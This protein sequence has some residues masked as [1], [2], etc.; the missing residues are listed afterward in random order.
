MTASHLSDEDRARQN[1]RLRAIWRKDAPRYDKMMGFFERRVLGTGHREWVCSRATGEVLEVAVG[2]GLNLPLYAPDVKLSA[3][4]LSPEMLALAHRRASDLGRDVELREADAHALPFENESFDSVVCTYAL[5]N[6]P[7]DRLAIHE[8]KRVLRPGGRLLLLDH[9][10]S[11]VKLVFWGQRA[12]EKLMFRRDGDH[13]TR[14][15][16]EH[17]IAQG[18][19]IQERDRFRWG[20]VERVHA[21]KP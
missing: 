13:Q 15:P 3:T 20:V 11:A 12:W 17:V 10:R 8:M 2:T 16:L 14:R 6:I 4:D 18:F 1:E 19:E 21:R 9:V 7:D 5:C